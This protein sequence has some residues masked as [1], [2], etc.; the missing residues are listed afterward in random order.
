MD[1]LKDAQV[2]RSD[3]RHVS[4]PYSKWVFTIFVVVVV[5]GAA[6]VYMTS[7]TGRTGQSAS[8]TVTAL[9]TVSNTVFNNQLE[10]VSESGV[11][12][13]SAILNPLGKL[14]YEAYGR[15]QIAIGCLSSPTGAIVCP[16]ILMIVVNQTGVVGMGEHVF[17]HK[18]SPVRT[19]G[20]AEITSMQ[21]TDF[22]LKDLDY[23]GKYYFAFGFMR[24][25]TPRIPY[26]ILSIT[27][28]ESWAAMQ[29][30]TQAAGCP[31]MFLFK[32]SPMGAAPI[33]RSVVGALSSVNP[34]SGTGDLRT[35]KVDGQRLI[36]VVQERLGLGFG[37]HDLTRE[38]LT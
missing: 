10:N 28:I 17:Q 32:A 27:L 33:I 19:Y 5:C 22:A 30:V 11:V 31:A 21:V 6:L 25:S 18:G 38:F 16:T 26:V 20:E 4:K 8:T 15:V 29:T 13:G 2:H 9:G 3:S 37:T 14:S 36:V 24:Q 35:I 7:Q 34:H 12:V 23:N 1:H